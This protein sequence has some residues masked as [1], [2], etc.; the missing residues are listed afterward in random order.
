MTRPLE[1]PI[2]IRPRAPTPPSIGRPLAEG[3]MLLASYGDLRAVK[4]LDGSVSIEHVLAA[5]SWTIDPSDVLT[6]SAYGLAGPPDGRWGYLKRGF[7]ELGR[8]VCWTNSNPGPD[9]EAV[10]TGLRELAAAA[11]CGFEHMPTNWD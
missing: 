4:H 7:D 2:P 11:G 3:S 5:S 9:E 1:T 6:F 10:A 8:F